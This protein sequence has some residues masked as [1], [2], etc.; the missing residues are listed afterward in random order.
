VA[1]G[2][3]AAGWL[4]EQAVAAIAVWAASIR[5]WASSSGRSFIGS[6]WA[7]GARGTLDALV[8]GGFPG[9]NGWKVDQRLQ[10]PF[11]ATGLRWCLGTLA[12]SMPKC[13]Q[14]D[15]PNTQLLLM[16]FPEVFGRVRFMIG[17]RP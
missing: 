8:L 10:R 1:F 15:E 16:I 6:G 2:C 11:A 4:A 17:A 12:R 3:G 7:S 9:W 13:D 5:C 14:T